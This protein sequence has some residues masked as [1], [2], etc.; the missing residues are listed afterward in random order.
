MF[1]KNLHCTNFKNHTSL[2]LSF[3]NH[4]NFI[5][6][7]NGVGKTNLLDSIH[8]LAL[9]KSAFNT[10]DA[11]NI[12]HGQEAFL[13][14]GCFMKQGSPY[15]VQCSFRQHQEKQLKTNNKTYTR[16]REHIG[17]FPIVL[18]TPYDIDLIRGGSESRRKFFDAML[19][20]LDRMYLHTLLQYQHLLRQRNSLLRQHNAVGQLDRDLL[21]TYDH[22]LLPLATQL[23]KA[24]ASWMKT[25]IPNFQQ[26]YQYLVAAP[27]K[28]Q[29]TYDSQVGTPN[30][31]QQFY[32]SLPQDLRL[33]RTTHGIHRDDVHFLLG[34]HLLRKVGSQGQQKSFIIAL[35]L[36]QFECMYN[37][38]QCKPLLLL[39]DI[40]DK[41]DEQRTDR[42][43]Q[44][45][46]QP[47]FGQV[48]ITDAK[49]QSSIAVI[50]RVHTPHNLIRMGQ[51]Q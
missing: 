51:K 35:K 13:I 4:L 15:Q 3:E 42:L 20:Q 48:F 50:Q 34:G 28:V 39:D 46:M 16:L 47:H 26:H 6:G 33:Q 30:F 27:E 25:F 43:V 9:T 5:I 11:K 49:A 10:Q 23:F 14:Q 32:N 24:R 7:P 1:L 21:A 17:L 44:L 45:M 29:L 18:T 2:D 40:F 41:L 8:Y 37:A 38:L 36:A 31:E 12:Q 19:C 22:Q